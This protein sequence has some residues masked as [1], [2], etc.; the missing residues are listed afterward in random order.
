MAGAAASCVVDAT[1]AGAER[2]EIVMLVELTEALWIVERP[3]GATLSRPW[4]TA[5]NYR[6]SGAAV[7]H[8]V[9]VVPWPV[10]VL[11]AGTKLVIEDIVP[12]SEVRCHER[13]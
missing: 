9:G 7:V 6:G 5:I 2:V 10:R 4:A 1:A 8:C 13:E 3:E 12:W 11:E